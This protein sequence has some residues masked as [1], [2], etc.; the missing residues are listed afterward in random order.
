MGKK[1]EKKMGGRTV[2]KNHH[3]LTSNAVIDLNKYK[4]RTFVKGY[5]R[6]G[7]SHGLKLSHHTHT[8]THTHMHTHT[9]PLSLFI[10][11]TPTLFTQSMPESQIELN[12]PLYR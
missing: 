1:R 6:T 3:T 7:Y 11:V 10:T 9:L 5:Y 2:V 8:C 12:Q 4:S